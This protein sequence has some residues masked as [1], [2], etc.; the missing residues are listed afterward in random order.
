M[1]SLKKYIPGPTQVTRMRKT[2][3]AIH[4]SYQK[5]QSKRSG[6]LQT[7]KSYLNQSEI[8]TINKSEK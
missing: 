8:N 2:P 5:T 7:E 3:E 6:K 4:P 1:I